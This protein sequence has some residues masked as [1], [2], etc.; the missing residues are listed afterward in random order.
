MVIPFLKTVQFYQMVSSFVTCETCVCCSIYLDSHLSHLY[1][2]LPHVTRTK[3]SG[4]VTG[5]LYFHCNNIPPSALTGGKQMEIRLQQWT[6]MHCCTDHAGTARLSC[7]DSV[8]T[9]HQVMCTL[10]KR[11]KRNKMQHVRLESE[12]PPPKLT[13]PIEQ[14]SY[15]F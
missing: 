15:S 9:W 5:P 10:D 14:S 4:H 6:V 1:T 7:K 8:T 12:F 3:M 11:Q 2:T 13:L